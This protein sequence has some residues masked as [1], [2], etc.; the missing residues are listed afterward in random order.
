MFASAWILEYFQET[1]LAIRLG[2]SIISGVND[3]IRQVI[4]TNRFRLNEKRIRAQNEQWL[5]QHRAHVMNMQWHTHLRRMYTRIIIIVILQ[6]WARLIHEP[7]VAMKHSR[8]A[9]QHN[10]HNAC[11]FI[12]AA[13]IEPGF[14]SILF[15]RQCECVMKLQIEIYWFTNANHRS[16][17]PTLTLR[18]IDTFRLAQE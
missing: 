11:H 7:I 16:P 4:A 3:V 6:I 5:R 12:S 17:Y 1:V 2:L 15:A 8:V 14:H 10:A 13:R 18:I 9:T